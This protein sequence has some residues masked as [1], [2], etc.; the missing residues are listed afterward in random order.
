MTLLVYLLQQLF[1]LSSIYPSNPLFKLFMY[2]SCSYVYPFIHLSIHLSIHIHRYMYINTFIHPSNF[3]YVQ[4]VIPSNHLFIHHLFMYIFICLCHYVHILYLLSLYLYLINRY[5][6]IKHLKVIQH[7]DK[8]GFSVPC[9][10]SES[11]IH[12]SENSLET[13]NPKL[14][15][16]LAYP[17]NS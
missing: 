12:Y 9:N 16:T 4:S 5:N 10:Y 7:E 17:L 6:G 15:T 8:Y 1:H 11:I 3:L 13:H 2:H 14:T